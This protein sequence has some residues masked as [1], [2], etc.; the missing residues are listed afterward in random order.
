MPFVPVFA[1]TSK[2]S[3]LSGCEMN[4]QIYTVVKDTDRTCSIY[5]FSENDYFNSNLGDTYKIG[6]LI[7]ALGEINIF[8]VLC[9]LEENNNIIKIYILYEHKY[10]NDDEE[11]SC[12]K[13]YQYDSDE[14]TYSQ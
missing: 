13:I 7:E 6:T 3:V 14:N 5:R 8:D 10:K 2:G 11:I 4:N 9:L 12:L 1:Q